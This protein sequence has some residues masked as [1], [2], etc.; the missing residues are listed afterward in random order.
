MNKNESSQASWITHYSSNRAL[1]TSLCL[2]LSLSLSHIHKHTQTYTHTH[3][4]TQTYI[5]NHLFWMN[6]EWTKNN[7]LFLFEFA[8]L[9]LKFLRTGQQRAL[10]T[11]M[12]MMFFEK[13]FYWTINLIIH[14]FASR[15][16]FLVFIFSKYLSHDILPWVIQD[17]IL[18]SVFHGVPN[19]CHIIP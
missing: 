12:L 10:R 8:K 11:L 14:W 9:S 18:P 7:F 13:W 19:Y 2:C 4:H 15:H 1:S 17:W 3:T 5:N 6:I 16:A